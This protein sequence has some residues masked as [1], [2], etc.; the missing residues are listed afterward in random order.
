M[1]IKMIVP[2]EV[3]IACR[4]LPAL[5]RFYENTMGFTFVSEITVSAENSA[6]SG[7]SADG[8]TVVR[9]QTPYGERIKLLAPNTPPQAEPAPA[10]ILDKP[11]AAYL[12]FIVDDIN[13][14]IA[15]LLDAGIH[16]MTGRQRVE[17]RPGVYL[18]FCRDP[19]GNVLELVEYSDIAA[20]RPDLKKAE[21]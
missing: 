17:A 15:K 4:D 3:G 16:F 8:Y 1:S 7:L 10:F 11:N 5:R 20:Y 6:P 18:A 12:T 21:N 13:A 14:A 9:L 2:M 19:E